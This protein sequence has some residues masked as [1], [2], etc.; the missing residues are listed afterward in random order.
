MRLYTC[1]DLRSRIG[2]NECNKMHTYMVYH[3]DPFTFSAHKHTH[4]LTYPVT[5]VV[6]EESANWK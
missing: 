4:R 3:V 5:L 6:K 2:Y 1:I